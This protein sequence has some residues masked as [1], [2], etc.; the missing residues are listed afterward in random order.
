MSIPSQRLKPDKIIK[1]KE[2]N[3]TL[4]ATMEAIVRTALNLDGVE[5]H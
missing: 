1:N 4:L 2:E 5:S 3:G